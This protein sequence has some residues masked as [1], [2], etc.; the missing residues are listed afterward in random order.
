MYEFVQDVVVDVYLSFLEELARPLGI[1]KEYP[2]VAISCVTPF[3]ILFLQPYIF[4]LYYSSSFVQ[5][6]YIQL[7]VFCKLQSTRNLINTSKT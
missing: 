7:S 6:L 2:V 1:Q 3:S 5:S 4:C